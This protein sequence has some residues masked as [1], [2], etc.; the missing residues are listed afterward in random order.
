MNIQN[1]KKEKSLLFFT[2]KGRSDIL[3]TNECFTS[4]DNGES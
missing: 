1:I 2:C 4:L 3:Y